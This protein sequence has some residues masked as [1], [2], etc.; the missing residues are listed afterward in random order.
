MATQR[1]NIERLGERLPRRSSFRQLFIWYSVGAFITTLVATGTIDGAG[2]IWIALRTHGRSPL[3]GDLASQAVGVLLITAVPICALIASVSLFAWIMGRRIIRPVAELMRAVE[4]IR[5]QDLDF[6]LSY[7]AN[8]ELGDLCSAIAELRGELQASLEREWREQE[9]MR[10][11]VATLAHDLRTPVTIIQGHIEGLARTLEG[12]KRSQR[13]ERYLPVLESNSQRM[14]RL[15]N[16]ILLTASLEQ[17]GSAPAL[18]TVSPEEEFARKAHMYQLQAATQGIAF[19]FSG[20]AQAAQPFLVRLDPHPVERILDN[21]FENALRY[22]PAAGQISLR[23]RYDREALSFVIRDSGYGI[24]TQD[25]SHVFEKFYRGQAMPAETAEQKRT[26]AGLGLYSCK[27]LVS[28]LGGTIT[29]QNIS[30][31]G[32]EARVRLP[33]METPVIEEPAH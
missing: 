7:S 19:S 3:F 16:D 10:L 24:A 14:T 25:L 12:E 26:G 23:Y 13:L 4:K 31:H 28:G 32:C 30:P 6:R 2:L 17:I 15:L 33:L 9:E 5:Q 29:I 8:D 11:Q 21:L 1:N 27:L 18:Q 20:G 22:T